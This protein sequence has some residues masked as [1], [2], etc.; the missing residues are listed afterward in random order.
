MGSGFLYVRRDRIKSHWPLTPANESRSEDIRKFEEIGTH[1]AAMHNAI[2]EALEFHHSI[3]SAR[4]AARLR[5]LRDRWARAL[6]ERP[7][8]RVLTSFDPAQGCAIGLLSLEGRDPEK[9]TAHL[10][11]RHRII[12][13]SIKH[14]EFQG[15]RITPNLYTTL[16]E[17]HTFNDAIEVFFAHAP[18]KR[19]APPESDD[20]RPLV[21]VRAAHQDIAKLR[22]L[23]ANCFHCRVLQSHEIDTGDGDSF[24]TQLEND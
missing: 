11:N 4:K 20:I 1:P 18:M 15:L 13:T 9:V 7:G 17:I 23:R 14:P 3:G 8:A 21:I 19:S 24:L 16:N 5:Y 6:H 10:W 12:V 22:Q 2:A